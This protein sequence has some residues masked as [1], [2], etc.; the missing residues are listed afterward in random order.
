MNTLTYWIGIRHSER[1]YLAHHQLFPTFRKLKSI[2]DGLLAFSVSEWLFKRTITSTNSTQALSVCLCI[3]ALQTHYMCMCSKLQSCYNLTVI[4]IYHNSNC[5]SSSKVRLQSVTY[6]VLLSFY[7]YRCTF[8]VLTIRCYW[9]LTCLLF[10]LINLDGKL[11]CLK[12][13]IS[14]SLS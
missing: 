8:D 11:L 4:I 7:G 12:G 5:T 2:F 6:R 10:F 3:T 14:F 9:I 1:V 13:V